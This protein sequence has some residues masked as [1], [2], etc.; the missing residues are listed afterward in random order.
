MRI[1]RSQTHN[2]TCPGGWF[3][4]GYNLGL[5]RSTV[6]V[7]G[8]KYLGRLILYVGGFALRLHRF[9][10]GDD[11]RAPHDHPWPFWTFPLCHGYME[12][13][14]DSRGELKYRFVRGWRPNYRTADYR[15]IVLDPPKPFYTLVFNGRKERSWGFWPSV[16]ED[17]RGKRVFVPWREWEERTK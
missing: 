8:E 16:Q 11:A 13:V 17:F 6:R 5:E 2:G 3:L 14:P 15:H 9:Y 1:F 12:L 10:R 4:G 7:G